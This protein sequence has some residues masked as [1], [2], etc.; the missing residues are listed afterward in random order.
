MDFFSHESDAKGDLLAVD[1]LTNAALHDIRLRVGQGEIVGIAG[2]EGAG[3]RDL[4]QAI[5]AARGRQGRVVASPTDIAYVSGDRKREG[6]LP[7]WSV[8]ENVEI[9]AV[10]SHARMGFV[11]FE[12]LR[13][14]A[15]GWCTRRCTRRS[16]ADWQS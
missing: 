15:R 10:S 13:S 11:D 3:Q 4:L 16:F 8:Q 1:R 6:L 7:I 5:F 9:S 2:L 14:T 12:G